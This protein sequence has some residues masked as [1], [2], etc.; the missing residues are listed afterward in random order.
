MTWEV[1]RREV[2]DESAMVPWSFY[3]Q[4][5]SGKNFF[6]QVPDADEF[7]KPDLVIKLLLYQINMGVVANR[8]QKIRQAVASVRQ[9]VEQVQQDQ[10]DIFNHLKQ[11]EDEI[12]ET[13]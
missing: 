3:R 10:D 7:E 1:S 12:E 11:L 4:E 6:V 2:A 8:L 5:K 13:E 9:S